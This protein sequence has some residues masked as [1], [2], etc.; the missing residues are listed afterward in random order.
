MSTYS[1]AVGGSNTNQDTRVNHSI[2]TYTGKIDGTQ[3]TIVAYNQSSG[4]HV[5]SHLYGH[6]DVH[7]IAM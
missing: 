7:D 4:A 3:E 6:S 1:F 5:A 2:R